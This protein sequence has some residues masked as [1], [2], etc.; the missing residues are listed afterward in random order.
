MTLWAWLLRSFDLAGED[1]LAASRLR[2][3]THPL[4]TGEQFFA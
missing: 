2:T 3:A 1:P 4:H